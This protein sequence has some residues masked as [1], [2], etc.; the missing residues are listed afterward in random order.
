[1]E[2]ISQID[3][4]SCTVKTLREELAR[5]GLQ[6]NGNKTALIRRLEEAL[7]AEKEAEVMECR[8]ASSQASL[9]SGRSVSSQRESEAVK[10]AELKAKA[11]LLE[12]KQRLLR[13]EMELKM[14]RE[15]LELQEEIALTEARE[16]A[17]GMNEQNSTEEIH[18][19]GP[20]DAAEGGEDNFQRQEMTAIQAL[21]SQQ[22]RS[23]LPQSQIQCFRGDPLEYKAFIRAFESRIASRTED[24]AERLHFLEQYTGGRPNNIVRSYMHIDPARGY[25]EARKAL[26]RKYGDDYKISKAYVDA[27]LTWPAIRATDITGL[28]D[29]SIKLRHCLNAMED[30][31]ALTEVNHPKNLQRIVA[32]LPYALQEGWRRTAFTI[33]RKDAKP[34][35]E[36]VVEFVEKE[37]EV[38]TDPVF[39]A[40]EMAASQSGSKQPYL[41]KTEEVMKRKKPKIYVTKTSSEAAKKEHCPSCKTNHDPEACQDM[42]K[43]GIKERLELIKKSGLCFGCL[44]PG[45]S[46]RQCSKRKTCIKCGGRHP[47]LLHADQQDQEDG[48]KAGLPSA[49]NSEVCG[50][51][52]TDRT[53]TVMSILPVIVTGRNGRKSQTYAF[54]DSGS[55]ATFITTSLAE[56]LKLSGEEIAL[57]L[58]TVEQDGLEVSSKVVTGLQVSSLDGSG[59]VM[60]PSTFTIGKIPVT[61]SDIPDASIVQRWR[62]LAGITIPAVKAEDVGLLIG[63]NC[64][65]AMEPWD[66]VHCEDGG[67]YAIKTRLGWTIVGPSDQKTNETSGGSIRVNRVGA[68]A[69]ED[70]AKMLT[71]MYNSD[72]TEKTGS[73][74]SQSVEDH[75]WEKRVSDSIEMRNGKYQIALPLKQEDVN[76][77]NNRKMAERRVESLKRKFE[78]DESFHQR[79]TECVED[80]I[81]EGHAEIVPRDQIDRPGKTWYL[82]HHAVSHPAKPDKTRVVFDCSARYGG[83]SLND[84]LLQGPDLTNSLFGVLLRFRQEQVGFMADIRSMF[85]MVRVP[86]E[87]ADLLRFLW[88]P[89]GDTSQAPQTYRM[90][91]HLFGAV[92]SPACANFALKKSAEDNWQ[93]YGPEVKST[94]ERNFY[95][96][97][98]LKSVQDA[99]T[100]VNLCE[101]LRSVCRKGGFHLTKFVSSDDLVM[102]HIPEEDRTAKVSSGSALTTG[103]AEKRALGILWNTSTDTMGFKVQV[104]KRPATRR[105][106]LSTISSI[107][108]PLG[109]VA[110]VL[111][112]PKILLQQL[113]Q[114]D[115][116]W[117]DPIPQHLEERWMKWME[118]LPKLQEFKIRR[119]YKP[120]EFKKIVSCQAHYFADASETG[121]GAVGYLRMVDE[122]GKIHCSFLAGKARVAPLKSVTIPRLELTA[123][124]VAVRLNAQVTRELEIAVDSSTFWT[125]STTVLRYINNRTSRFQTYVA[126]R[127]Q[128]IHEH[129]DPDQW[130]FV[131]GVINPADEASRGVPME[132][133]LQS[134]RWTSA[135]EFLWQSEDQWPRNMSPPA[136]L[137]ISDPEVKRTAIISATST[138]EKSPTDRLLLRYSSWYRLKRAVAYILR[139]KR[140]LKARAEQVRATQRGQK[141]EDGESEPS[142]AGTPDRTRHQDTSALLS[143]EEM[144][145]A[146]TAIVIFVQATS[147]QAE[148][149]KLKKKE[150]VKRSSPINRLDPVLQQDVLR[151]GGRLG[152]SLEAYESKHPAILP[153][154]THV[155]ELIIQHV[156]Q[157]VGHQGRQHVLASLREK[158]WVLRANA[159]VR[160]VLSRCLVCRRLQARPLTQKM[161]NLPEDRVTPDHP[162][163]SFSAVDL[164]GP[165]LVKRGRSMVKR[166]GVL[167]TCLTTRAVHIELAHSL[168]TD[169]FVNA[170]RRFVS[171]RGE[172][173]EIRSDNGTNFVGAE[174]ELREEIDKW[175]QQQIHE[176]ML[177]HHI[178][179]KFNPPGASHH[180]GVWE[181]QIRSVR[182][183]LG[184][185]LLSQTI[186]EEGLTTL[187][188]EVESILNSRPLT[189]VSDDPLDLDPLTPNHLLLLR[190]GTRLPPGAFSNSDN[191][192]RRRWRQIQHLA[193]EFWRRWRREYLQS[194]QQRQKWTKKERNLQVGD[195]VI[196]VDSNAPRSTWSIGRVKRVLP[197]AGGVVR[198]VDV[199]T[200]SAVLSRPVTKLVLLAEQAG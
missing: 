56:K 92:S 84:Q 192:S 98:C 111:M 178:K 157:T 12:E 72:F 115:L 146:E 23:L 26:D 104:M 141:R 87:D 153:A 38:A 164:F 123:A 193:S 30:I 76:M 40:A 179:W 158:F 167:F 64:P 88:W 105:G 29:F 108:D 159:A 140:Y 10:K 27:L 174:R 28:E 32:K 16:Q 177:Q 53:R 143:P 160:R 120:A 68:S 54:L 22:K 182:K 118:D 117:D 130:R 50:G 37:V 101:Q 114:L 78:R 20:Q 17:L 25:A 173:R 151:V 1:M 154:K 39:G 163:F 62:H 180:G 109:F 144:E 116:G 59:G 103:S 13:E 172:V 42:L 89:K 102:E 43:R 49:P 91:V 36:N 137:D 9:V 150:E 197:D 97:D 11:A 81:R 3:L 63:C 65:L 110:P 155:T 129:S 147:Y 19:M 132:K 148:I 149:R 67:P 2:D 176:A 131:D 186:D 198:V 55:S 51:T 139:L 75:L 47:T 113:C 190:S 61:S 21:L 195:V 86:E 66:V 70:I 134:S 60:L 194:L 90:R 184:S 125:D 161:A 100:A 112:A 200:K 152:R 7:A 34:S 106:M 181:R 45:H 145:E 119:C 52:K 44:K 138:S 58:T 14:K 77:P 107:F 95:V 8:S 31:S 6:R 126:N 79:Y 187:L 24:S 69:K 188:C 71:K 48:D 189:P 175:N 199:Q 18:S 169:S 5:R 94:I 82:P 162:P 46:S 168:T 73:E 83:A 185:L 166:Y 136:H 85:H 35:F 122:E 15:R 191:Y 171:R 80:L 41:N 99:E 121:Y 142:A 196:I 74:P 170:L 183:I 156:H 124:T 33:T 128:V 135:P 57:T 4:R 127:V 93:E 96:D 133:F 165:F